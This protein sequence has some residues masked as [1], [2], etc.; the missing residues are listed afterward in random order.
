MLDSLPI[1]ELRRSFGGTNPIRLI[2]S[3]NN[4]IPIDCS[5]TKQIMNSSGMIT[6]PSSPDAVIID[7]GVDGV[8]IVYLLA[9]LL[10][11]NCTKK[12]S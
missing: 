9:R 11:A 6:N 1:L 12:T 5:V 8:K 4:L 10:G 7:D 2:G 3:L